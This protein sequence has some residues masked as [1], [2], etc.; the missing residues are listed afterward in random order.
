MDYSDLKGKVV[1]IAGASG[2]IG[3]E[4]AEAF[5]SKRVQLVLVGRSEEKLKQTLLRCQNAGA[6][7]G[8]VITISCDVTNQAEVDSMIEKTVKTFGGID[9]L[10]NSVGIVRPGKFL[11][12]KSQDYDDVFRINVFGPFSVVKAAAC[13][14]IKRRGSIV[15]VSSFTGIRPSYAYF[16]YAL[17]EAALDQLTK[18]LALELGPQG[19][20]V[21]SVNPAV[22]RGSD[23]W[24][25]EGAPLADRKGEYA[26]I[27]EG[28]KQFYPMG[29]L[30]E[31]NDVAGAIVFLASDNASFVTGALMPIDGGKTLTSKAAR[32]DAPTAKK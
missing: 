15:N 14:L 13:H 25:R 18:A 2:N 4:A 1:L 7:D 6:K 22:I 10:V 3:S 8:D 29:R 21:N 24:I 5:A 9:V 28:L 16:A 17:A 30:V 20:R 23:F 26:T 11:E 32:D 27:Q 12:T 19:V 31:V